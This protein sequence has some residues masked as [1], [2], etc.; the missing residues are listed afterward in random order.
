M[1]E[2]A[3]IPLIGE[4]APCFIAETTQG[5]IRFPEDYKGSWVIFF[6]HPADFTPVCTTEFMAFA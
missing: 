5:P 3:R 1:E 6:S 4:K 2:Q